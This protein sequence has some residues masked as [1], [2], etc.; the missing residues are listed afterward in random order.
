MSLLSLDLSVGKADAGNA[1]GE[2]APEKAGFQCRY[3]GAAVGHVPPSLVEDAA[4]SCALCGLARHLE[5]A[6]IKEEARLIWLP[7][8]SQAALNAV[9]RRV[10][11]GLRGLGE[12]MEPEAR[13]VLAAGDGLS[14]YHLQQA[15]LERS[16]EAEV[17][18][19]TTDPG[20]LGDGLVRL[21]AGAY[22]RRGVL[23]GGIR[24]LPA[25]RL[26]EGG[27]DIYPVVVD[28]WRQIAA[29]PAGGVA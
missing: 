15:L 25:G 22:A 26:F 1:R 11:C 6:R 14:L 13:P 28:R 12:R 2:T 18:L 19:G 21:S 17:R 3:C 5:R 8:M 10:H 16:R 27:E 20:A 4:A 29:R 7:E 23:L 24:L 9:M